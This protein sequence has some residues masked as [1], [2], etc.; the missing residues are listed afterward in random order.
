MKTKQTIIRGISLG[1]FLLAS[2]GCNKAPHTGVF[3]VTNQSGQNTFTAS[4]AQKNGIE[5]LLLDSN[6][7]LTTADFQEASFVS[8]TTP[9][10][11][12]KLTPQGTEKFRLATKNALN[13]RIAVILY[14]KPIIAPT[15]KAE[16]TN[17]TFVIS[18]ENTAADEFQALAD[19][20]QKDIAK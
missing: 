15:V 14:G 13:E 20:L 12:V 5:Q 3:R 10:I 18:G 1:V 16:I 8:G 19:R 9:A 17:G 7:I 6:P 2:T 11:S 4:L